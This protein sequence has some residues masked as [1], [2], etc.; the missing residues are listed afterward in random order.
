MKPHQRNLFRTVI[1]SISAAIM[2]AACGGGGSASGGSGPQPQASLAY[3]STPMVL[4]V[5]VAMTPV[6]PTATPGLSGFAVVPTLPPGLRLDASSGTLS[7]TPTA[8]SST[9]T[10]T[11]TASG[12]GATA[13]AAV[14]ITVNPPA[15]SSLSYGAAAFSFTAGIAAHT[16][17]PSTSG[18]DVAAWSIA[19][20]LP[21]GLTFSTTDGAISGTPTAASP[22]GSYVVTAR[23]A[24]GKATVTLQIEID[25]HVLL[26][27][28]HDSALISLRMTGSS[29]LSVDESGH[30]ILWDY[31]TA[32]RIASGDLDCAPTCNPPV[33]DLAGDTIAFRTKTGFQFRSATTGNVLSNITASQSW[34][35]L[36]S[37]GSYLVAGSPEGLSAWSPSGDSLVS[38]SGAY[39][40]AISFAGPGQIQLA[41]GPSGQSVIQTVTVPGGASTAGPVFSGQFSSW[42]RDGSRFITTAG[43]TALVYSRDS[44]QQA[45][46]TLPAGATQVV[47][48]GNWLWTDLGQTLDVFAIATSSTPAASFAI[49]S[50]T[51]PI[52]SGPTIA[53]L[54][55]SGGLTVI[56]LSGSTPTKTD[57]TLPATAAG[58][59]HD[60]AA[61]SA[62]RWMI[63]NIWGVLLDGASVGGTPRYFD[64]GAALSITGS[65]GRI[66]VATAS[67]SI[68]YFDGSTLTQEG[69]IPDLAAKVLLSSDGSVLVAAGDYADFNYNSDASIKIYSLPGAGLLYTWPGLAQEISLSASGA[70]LG[71]V[72]LTEGGAG[73]SPFYTQRADS[74]TGGASIF[75]TT[76]DSQILSP[77]P[78]L[79]VSPNGT[80][81]ATSMGKASGGTN[82]LQNGSLVTAVTGFPIGW[83]D[84]GHLLVN[85]YAQQYTGCGVY[86]AAGQ[87]TGP[88]AL[89]EVTAFQS[90]TA[91]TIYAVNL[92]EIVSIST[93]DV[94]WTSADAISPSTGAIAGN[95]V[96]FV[97][98][99][100]V[101][102]QAY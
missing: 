65:N 55:V 41:D 85:T 58:T 39:S 82:I 23:N 36:A 74:T 100:Q 50:T 96:V 44:V 73:V 81:L 88:C 68:V 20:A 11:I 89:P 101:I 10:Y 79:L 76:F 64:Y 86:S 30:W 28:G 67:G 35:K 1:T 24:G 43:T 19:P 60:Y 71:Q 4:V 97:S 37:D 18:G 84:D 5:G 3:P 72:L 61:L 78:P 46:I 59:V 94:N 15:P 2:L 33:A 34:W 7:G 26:D 45:A 38:L 31:A 99:E 66:A 69:V 22:P 98:G 70:V 75:S 27:L 12:G 63:G 49:A 90:L 32:A 14:S 29:V 52:S 77:P 80:L 47:G 48:Q 9:G 25:D 93:G 102:A 87:K 54:D 40:G 51:S 62:S 42:F 91:D 92:A 13:R 16:L 57:Y 17:T 95:H 6:A 8:V 21:A 53:V 56:D 83:I